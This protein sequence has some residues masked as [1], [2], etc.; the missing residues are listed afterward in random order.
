M[1]LEFTAAS[2]LLPQDVIVHLK[3]QTHT[4]DQEAI[5]TFF[6]LSLLLFT[7]NLEM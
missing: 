5:G 2:F 1:T 6:L 4:H 7:S 3:K